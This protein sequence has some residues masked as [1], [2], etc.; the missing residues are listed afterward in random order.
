MN[1]KPALTQEQVRDLLQLAGE[2][3]EEAA[4]CAASAHWRT[5]LMTAGATLETVLLATA[6]CFEPELK[7]E[8]RWPK[9]AVDRWTLG[10]LVN[11]AVAAGWLPSTGPASKGDVLAP[12]DGDVGDAVDFI[13]RLRNMSA[14][15]GAYAREPVRPDFRDARHMRPTD[16]IVEGITQRVFGLLAAQIDLQPPPPHRLSPERA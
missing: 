6:C 5:A 16:A 15:P 11:L 10:E 4:R 2:L 14:H 13:C 12:L 7:A 9:K 1:E 3:W 8:G